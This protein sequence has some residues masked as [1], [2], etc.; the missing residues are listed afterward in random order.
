MRNLSIQKLSTQLSIA[1]EYWFYR[2]LI[3]TFINTDLVDE[4]CR[5]FLSEYS[6]RYIVLK[7]GEHYGSFL[8]EDEPYT[9]LIWFD[10]LTI[11]N[12]SIFS[13]DFK[14]YGFE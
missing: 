7:P 12:L 11:K 6:G 8:K 13:T 1:Y 4:C 5:L 2:Y 10:G 3:K 14:N 9:L